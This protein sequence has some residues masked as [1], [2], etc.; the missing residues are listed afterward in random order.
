MKNYRSVVLLIALAVVLVPLV[1]HAQDQPPEVVPISTLSDSQ[2]NG[3]QLRTFFIV[4]DK[5]TGRVIPSN[6]IESAKFQLPNDD[7]LV[8]ADLQ[9]PTTPIK[10][11]LLMD[12]SG[13]MKPFIPGVRAAAKDAISKAP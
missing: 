7:A 9:S 6:T 4:R 8:P 12:E 10:I 5:A 13:S 2:A 3:L 1:G 11:A